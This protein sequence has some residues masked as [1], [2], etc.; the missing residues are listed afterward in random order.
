MIKHLCIPVLF[1]LA[2][3]ASSDDVVDVVPDAAVVVD[4]GVGDASDVSDAAVVGFDAAV[5]IDA[6]PSP[7]AALPSSLT[8]RNTS[9][10]IVT[11]FYLTPCGLPHGANILGAQPLPPGFMFTIDG[12]VAGCYDLDAANSLVRWEGHGETIEADSAYTWTLTD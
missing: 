4:A 2:C 5:V 10:Y 1:L 12:I 3:N 7:D 8:V 11:E 9:S 6:A